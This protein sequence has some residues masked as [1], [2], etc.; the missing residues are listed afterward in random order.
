MTRED[1]IKIMAVLKV[2][3]PGF[4]RD[5]SQREAELAVNLWLSQLEDLTYPQAVAAVKALISQDTK[6]YPPSVGQVRAKAF[7]LFAPE[8]MSGMEAWS[9][10]RKACSNG[11]YGSQEEFEKLPPLLKKLVGS[12]QTLRDWAQMD[13]SELET[14]VQS[15]FVRSYRQA[16]ERAAERAML[17]QSVR[18]HLEEHKWKALPGEMEGE[19]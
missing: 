3:Y 5:L 2:A 15:H 13:L 10:I 17:P 9:R 6:G 12:P 11:I 8:Q 19:R 14:V 1:I 4:Q 7:D 16:A 18:L